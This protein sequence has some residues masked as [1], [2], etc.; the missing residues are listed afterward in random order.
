MK[1]QRQPRRSTGCTKSD[2]LPGEKW[3]RKNAAWREER[4]KKRE[5]ERK[6]ER[7]KE[8]E[9]RTEREQGCRREGEII[10]GES[11]LGRG[12]GTIR[13]IQGAGYFP[14]YFLF[15]I[16]SSFPLFLSLSPV[17]LHLISYIIHGG[18]I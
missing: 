17:L 18:Y 3:K 1:S 2:A 10:G 12:S 9:T 16:F 6:K 15:S 13:I 7:K 5:R 8:R 11:F 14:C 4:E